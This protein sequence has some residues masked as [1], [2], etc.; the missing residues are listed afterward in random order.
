MNKQELLTKLVTEGIPALLIQA[1]AQVDRE[2]FVPEKLKFYVYEDTA[3]PIAHGLTL[4]PLSVVAHMLTAL[5]LQEGQKVLEI[6][7]GSGY[8]LALIAKAYP[9]TECYGLEINPKVAIETAKR[10]EPYK[11]IHIFAKS[12]FQGFA[13]Q[14]PFDRIIVSAAAD[15][16]DILLDLLP[17]VIDGGII[18][19]PIGDKLIHI[20]RTGLTYIKTEYPGTTFVPLLKDDTKEK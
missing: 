13:E 19:G 7:A 18:L 14:A 6:G 15:S 12:G 4:P 3:L 2:Q 20:K 16:I 5:D 11:N 8:V 17:Q 9:L 10:L 1:I